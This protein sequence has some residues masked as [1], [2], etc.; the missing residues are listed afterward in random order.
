MVSQILF[1]GGED[2]SFIPIGACQ[3][4]SGGQ[5]PFG[6]PSQN[7]VWQPDTTSGH[8]RPGYSRYALALFTGSNSGLT[9][10]SAWMRNAASFSSSAFWTSARFWVSTN[11]P[12]SSSQQ[13]VR[14]VDSGGVV[15]LR[16][17][18]NATSWPG[19]IKLE[20]VNA[21]GSVTTLATSSGT[22]GSNAPGIPDKLDVN[23]NYAVSGTF[24][25]Y[26]NGVQIVTYSG[27]VTTDAQTVLSNIDFGFLS[28]NNYAAYN[29]WS[30]VIVAT[31]DT[32]NMS[33]VTQVPLENGN[34]DAWTTSGG[35]TT[36]N[37]WGLANNS[38]GRGANEVSF[39]RFLVGLG[40]TIATT[41][42]SLTAGV[43]GTSQM[44]M[45]SDN[46]GVPGTLLG[47]S[48][49]IT[50]PGIGSTNYTFSSPV[51]VFG[52]TYYWLAIRCTA[53][54]TWPYNSAGV[55][56]SWFTQ[57]SLA[58]FP[59]NGGG[60]TNQGTGVNISESYTLTY[61]TVGTGITDT[62]DADSSATATQ[63]QE[64]QV[65]P[66]LPTGNYSIVS[67]V[68]HLST[69]IGSS[70]PAN[71]QAAVRTGGTDYFSSN[72]GPPTLAFATYQYNW[73]TNP[74]TAVAWLQTDLPSASTSFNMG[75]KSIT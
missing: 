47:S 39:N 29:A 42:F 67:L 46:A 34:T 36:Y 8:F 62:A 63:I 58:S 24:T 65:S 30:E 23:I 35:V 54:Y 28:W 53:A 14:F 64:Y 18:Q 22:F 43:T 75:Y 38:A 27:D 9:V 73:D 3:I 4:G 57:A 6:S 48:G 20:K 26:C 11:N 59:S 44:A 13:L 70:G 17:T 2:I 37:P 25:V 52:N 16:I 41:T 12:A 66:S 40:G 61:P 33:L 31:R 19:T 21:A 45:Y 10:N 49:N 15:R 32:R 71:I 72:L 74:N 7:T 51:I 55:G 5:T 56:L 50:N 60:A 69:T 1:C 68:T